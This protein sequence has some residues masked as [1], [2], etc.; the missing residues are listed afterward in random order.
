MTQKITPDDLA[1]WQ[2][3]RQDVKPLPKGFKM[4]PV[5]SS[6]KK[7]PKKIQQQGIFLETFKSNPDYSLVNFD[8]RDLKKLLIEATLDLHGYRIA[9][10]ESTLVKFLS[11]S[12]KRG[13]RWVLI[14]TGKGLHSPEQQ[15][16]G[17]KQTVQQ[18]FQAFSHLIIGFCPAKPNHGGEGA[19]YAKIRR[20]RIKPQRK[21]T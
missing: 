21:G 12:Q 6:H 13:Y 10:V 9:E 1:A 8:S 11:S 4:A 20:F 14:I 7:Q 18:L 16:S 5:V 2:K 15:R 17:I 3:A 19:F